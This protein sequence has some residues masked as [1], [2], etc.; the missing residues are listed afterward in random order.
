MQNLLKAYTRPRPLGAQDEATEA[1]ARHAPMVYRMV[2][3]L[4]E[5]VPASVDRQDLFNA[6]ILG[7]LTAIERFDA[8]RGVAFEAYAQIRIR[9]A[10]IDELRRR[11][12]LSR[13]M[14]RR[15]R[16]I[17]EQAEELERKLGRPLDPA[18]LAERT[19][20]SV[21]AVSRSRQQQP[22]PRP[23]APEL[24][25]RVESEPLWQRPAAPHEEAASREQIRKVSEALSALPER[26]RLIVGLYYEAQLTLKEIGELL[27]ISESRVSQLLRRVVRRVRAH[28]EAH[29]TPKP[30][31]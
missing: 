23:M 12:H 15:T 6:G 29:N 14:R 19:G 16:E 10:V 13:R 22:T 20:L 1:I 21:E 25:D 31:P 11:D 18:E 2:K 24:L 8:S 3:R 9:G 17:G 26:S 30:T 4:A 28:I 5:R 27:G 7:L